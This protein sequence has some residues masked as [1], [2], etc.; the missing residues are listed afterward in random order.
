MVDEESKRRRYEQYLLQRQSSLKL[1]PKDTKNVE[2]LVTQQLTKDIKKVKIKMPVLS[3]LMPYDY[4]PTSTEVM[5]ATRGREK[6]EETA[7]VKQ[8][9]LTPPANVSVPN[10]R[11]S[12]LDIRN[13]QQEINRITKDG[14]KVVPRFAKK[15][16]SPAKSFLK[17]KVAQKTA[18][19]AI[20]WAMGSTVAG[21]TGL[22]I[23]DYLIS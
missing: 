1:T 6:I 7:S 16:P 19:K 9:T 11:P 18:G 13:N 17:K 21:G 4:S 2:N 8:T 5:N 3:P 20:A 22:G 10:A 14:Q 23:L 15:Q 12:A